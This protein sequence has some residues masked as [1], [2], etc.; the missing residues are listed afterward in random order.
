MFYEDENAFNMFV[1]LKDTHNVFWSEQ[2]MQTE[3]LFL[4]KKTLQGT[5]SFPFSTIIR[6]KC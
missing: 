1:D 4:Y 5:F 3:T 6:S 2:G